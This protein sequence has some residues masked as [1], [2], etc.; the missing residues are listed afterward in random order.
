MLIDVN[1]INQSDSKVIQSKSQQRDKIR[2]S[3]D[4]KLTAYIE[5][6][7][8]QI[9]RSCILRKSL[10]EQQDR[11]LTEKQSEMRREQEKIRQDNIRINQQI[12]IPKKIFLNLNI[13]QILDF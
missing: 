2:R 10:S 8:E 6:T 1:R 12:G 7:S 9:A 11:N 5:S 13:C 3:F 4:S